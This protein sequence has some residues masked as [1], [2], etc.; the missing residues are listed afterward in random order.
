MGGYI[1]LHYGFPLPSNLPISSFLYPFHVNVGTLLFNFPLTLKSVMKKKG[2]KGGSSSI[3]GLL[4]P[5]SLRR[6]VSLPILS[7]CLSLEFTRK[8]IPGRKGLI[9]LTS[10]DR[11]RTTIEIHTKWKT[12]LQYTR[13]TT[14]ISY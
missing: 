1:H 12:R 3:R 6:P 10:V 9:L 5:T 2:F 4:I 13:T 14:R 8:F 7:V 11:R